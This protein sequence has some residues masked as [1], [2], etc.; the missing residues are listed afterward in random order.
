MYKLCFIAELPWDQPTGDCK[1][2]AAWKDGKAVHQTPW[3]KLD[4]LALSL[5]R[6]I[7]VP[8]PSG[9]LD[10]KQIR[11]HRW[12]NKYFDK[13]GKYIRMFVT[14]FLNFVGLGLQT[15]DI[16]HSFYY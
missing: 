6:K 8:L 9:R 4:P 14:K 3:S 15:P 5:V 2:Y 16:L 7:L 1:E 10:I 11:A 13:L 12:C